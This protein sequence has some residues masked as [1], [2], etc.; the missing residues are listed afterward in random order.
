MTLCTSSLCNHILVI[1]LPRV[2]E[3][4]VVVKTTTVIATRT[5]LFKQ[6]L[7]LISKLLLSFF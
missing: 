5:F 1:Q 7:L 3:F 4:T 2:P 6:R